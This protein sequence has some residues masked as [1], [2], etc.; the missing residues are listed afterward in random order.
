LTSQI[1]S[2]ATS[3]AKAV[4]QAVQAILILT[5]MSSASLDATDRRQ[6][7]ALS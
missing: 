3:A 7:D 1:T 4:K 5:F 6:P 2:A